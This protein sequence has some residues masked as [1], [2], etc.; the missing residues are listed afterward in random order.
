MAGR[1]SCEYETWEYKNLANTATKLGEEIVFAAAGYLSMAIE[2]ATQEVEDNDIRLDKIKSYELHDVAFLAA[3]V[4]PEDD[5]G[6]EIILTLCPVHLNNSS[7]YKNQYT[8]VI[9]SITMSDD[10]EQSLE[11]SRG[12]ISVIIDDTGT[13]ATPQNELVKRLCL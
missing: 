1:S 12:R 2:A 8:F 10:G 6:V 7:N 3:L 9:S 11:H 5:R 4:V 13:S